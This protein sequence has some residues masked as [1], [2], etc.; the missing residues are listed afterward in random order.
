MEL[1]NLRRVQCWN[2]LFRDIRFW[3]RKNG[4]PASDI[5]VYIDDIAQLFHSPSEQVYKQKLVEC[6]KKWDTLFKEYYMKEIDASVPNE[7]GRW[8]LEP[9]SI[10]NPYSGVTN[11]QSEGLNR[12]MKDFQ[13]WKEAPLDTLV[14]AL[15]Q[16]QVYYA[17]EV[18]RGFAGLGQYHLAETYKSIKIDAQDVEYIRAC[19]PDEIVH[20]IKERSGEQS[21]KHEQEKDKSCSERS[22]QAEDVHKKVPLS[23]HARATSVVENDQIA[24]NPRM[25]VFNVKGTSGITRVVTLFPQETCS[26]PSSG[27]CYHILAVKMSLGIKESS[28]PQRKNL[29]EL[30][31]NTRCRKEKKCGRKKPRPNDIKDDQNEKG[32]HQLIRHSYT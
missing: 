9:L 25:Y 29:A 3:L 28:A 31:R 14:L 13:S 18:R 21:E 7:V 26:C 5:T 17:N 2:H 1:P 23:I 32:S 12:M 6:C 20:N 8:V 10:Y 27:T 11:N 22:E 24:F 19:T 4:A 15:Y 30:R 16:L